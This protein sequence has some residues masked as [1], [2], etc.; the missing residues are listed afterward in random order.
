M[1]LRGT[2]SASLTR[3]QRQFEI[4]TSLEFS[5]LLFCPPLISLKVEISTHML[6][7][8]IPVYNEEDNVANTAET[9]LTV[10]KNA[11]IDCELIFV[12]DGS[13]DASWRCIAECAGENPHIRGLRFSRN[14]GKE[15]AIFAGLKAAAGDCSVVID[16]DLQHPPELIPKMYRLWEEGAEVVEAVKASRG[17]E[18]IFYKICAGFFYKL[19]RGSSS[20]VRLEG[21]SDFKLLDKKAVAALNDLP[22]RLTFFRA[23][24]SWIGFKTAQVPFEV[25]PR[26]SGKSKF[27]FGKLF[28]FAMS[29]ITS[30]TNLPMQFITLMGVLFFVMA[31]VVGIITLYIHF[32]GTGSRGFPTVILLILITGAVLMIGQGVTGYYIS[33]IY[34]E[35]KFRPRYIVEE[36]VGDA[37]ESLK[38]RKSREKSGKTGEPSESE[39]QPKQP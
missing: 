4:R 39:I 15:G 21:A 26:H 23:L 8:I 19:M 25:Q 14:F 33:K 13:Q 18:S 28:K 16:C 34:E 17:K 37:T 32:T 2:P 11:N 3:R 38:S 6:S 24:S 20:Q 29:N 10:L 22:E 27:N 35:I 36:T 30:F 1:P 7:V 9:L 12:D 31:V 5:T